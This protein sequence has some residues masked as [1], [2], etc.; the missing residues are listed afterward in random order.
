M[1]RTPAQAQAELLDL[2]PPGS[3]F[4][5]DPASNW[6]QFLKP[7]GGAWADYEAS[8]DSMLPQ[9]DPRTAPQF[10][11]DFLRVL[12][13]D[14]CGRDA[15]SQNL[16][17]AGLAQLAYQRWTQRMSETPADYIALGAAAGQTIAVQE[18]APSYVGQA[19]CGA[20]ACAQEG[21]QFSWQVT[22]GGLQTEQAQ[23]GGAVCGDLIGSYVPN[24][25]ACVIKRAAPS[26]TTPVFLYVQNYTPL[27]LV[28][29]WQ[30]GQGV[31]GAGAYWSVGASTA[32]AP[33]LVDTAVWLTSE[34]AIPGDSNAAAFNF[35][36]EV[37]NQYAVS[38]YLWLPPGVAFTQAPFF[39]G[40]DFTGFV[41]TKAVDPTITGAWQEITAT[42]VATLAS[43]PVVVAAQ[44]A[45]G[46]FFYLTLPNAQAGTVATDFEGL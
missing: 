7:I 11:G 28:P 2:A 16:S 14:P 33:L 32:V 42:G 23:C 17:S 31:P 36:A 18:F 24:L 21:V 22:L 43:Q 38:I 27:N 39:R 1:A 40:D 29:N 8:A 30:T 10:L 15:P 26:H 5:R 34:T 35:P 13:A 46:A 20:A 6:G 12:G 44:G 37:G 9:V 4:P 45:I 3:A 25:L 41:V 19:V